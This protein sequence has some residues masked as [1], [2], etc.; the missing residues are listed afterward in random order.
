MN[1]GSTA[2]ELTSFRRNPKH[3]KIYGKTLY[4][5]RFNLSPDAEAIWSWRLHVGLHALKVLSH[6]EINLALL[7]QGSTAAYVRNEPTTI[8]QI[9]RVFLVCQIFRLRKRCLFQY[10]IRTP[11]MIGKEYGYDRP[12]LPHT[13]MIDHSEPGVAEL[14]CYLYT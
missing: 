7:L 12:P 13:A 10:R 1:E 6:I 11:A 4:W 8:L 5:K 2:V 14:I 3:V 9:I